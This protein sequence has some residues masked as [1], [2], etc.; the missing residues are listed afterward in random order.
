MR[1]PEVDVV[2]VGTADEGA[3]RAVGTTG[4]SAAAV[5]DG[6]D[7]SAVG[8]CGS[9][10]GAPGCSGTTVDFSRAAPPAAEAAPMARNSNSTESIAR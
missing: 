10:S 4:G 2:G 8:E 1:A 9:G 6:S 7:R 3:K 5:G